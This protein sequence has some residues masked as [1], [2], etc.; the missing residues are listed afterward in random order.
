MSFPHLSC[1]SHV[2]LFMKRIHII[3]CLPPFSITCQTVV[4]DLVIWCSSPDIAI[5]KERKEDAVEPSYAKEW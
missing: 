3:A 1:L 4:S 5:P 2:L